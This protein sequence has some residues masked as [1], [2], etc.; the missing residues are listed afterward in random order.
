MLDAPELTL[1]RSA[2]HLGDYTR[3][4]EEA[5]NIDS[6]KPEVEI[7]STFYVLRARLAQG[8]Y[9]RVH[10][11]VKESSPMCLQ[12]LRLLAKYRAFSS[13][14]R[15]TSSIFDTLDEWLQDDTVLQ[16]SGTT[17]IA[18][19]I[20][21]ESQDYKNG[22]RLLHESKT[23]EGLALCVQM[24]L[25]IQRPDLAMKTVSKMQDIDD[26][27]T[28]CV[29]AVAW[30]SM[31]MAQGSDA[32]QDGLKDAFD[33][34]Q[35]LQEKFGASIKLLNTLGAC[36]MHMGEYSD[37]LGYLK[38]AREMAL[39]SG[40][41]PAAETLINSISCLHHLKKPPAVLER[42]TA[43]LRKA[44]PKHTWLQNQVEINESF[45]KVVAHYKK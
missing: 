10:D 37:A 30:V 29:F 19:Q 43:E 23:L 27:D 21:E 4:Y 40:Q 3:V 17:L 7:G 33:A 25:R 38:S 5:E 1:L 26:D 16:D 11:E 42:V 35:D 32:G 20:Y 36:Q 12:A 6:V 34:L 24:Q 8:E 14:G 15:D 44:H 31:S 9:K 13:H 28:L 41:K 18:A 22:L 2:F 39:T 45:S